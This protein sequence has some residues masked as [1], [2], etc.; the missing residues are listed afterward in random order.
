MPPSRKRCRCGTE[1]YPPRRPKR[2]A[3]Y[4][5][6][7]PLALDMRNCL[8]Q[9]IKLGDVMAVRTASDERERDVLCVDDEG[10]LVAKLAG[11]GDWGPFFPTER[12]ESVS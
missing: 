8:D 2:F 9:R 11:P 6:G 10:V 5:E 12:R 7:A 1:L 3:V 4:A